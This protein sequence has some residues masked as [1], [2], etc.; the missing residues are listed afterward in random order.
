V[1][2]TNHAP[3]GHGANNTPKGRK[4]GDK[5]NEKPDSMKK[6]EVIDT[7]R[8]LADDMPLNPRM[9]A[10][11]HEGTTIDEDGV[12]ICGSKA[13]ILSV[14]THLKPLLKY[15]NGQTRLGIAFSQIQDKETKRLIPDAYRCSVQVHERGPDAQHMNAMI[16]A[17]QARRRAAQD[18]VLQG[19]N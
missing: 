1:T 17:V 18:I 6:Q 7:W 16:E 14:L 19:L 15:E 9:I 12:R 10:Y 3:D 5:M 11:K 13:F 2:I 8:G 4:Q